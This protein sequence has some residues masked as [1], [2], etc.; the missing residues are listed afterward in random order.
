MSKIITQKCKI[1][2]CDGKG[3]IRKSG[4]ESF[5]K[6]YCIKHYER[7]RHQLCLQSVEGA[8]AYI[9]VNGEKR[10]CNGIS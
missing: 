9:E 5:I 7:Y 4:Y 1:E 3:K 2:N 10:T 6:G 8:D